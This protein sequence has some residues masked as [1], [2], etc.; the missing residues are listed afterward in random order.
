MITL[1]AQTGS[2]V[3]AL[4]KGIESVTL[5]DDL[6]AVITDGGFDAG[7]SVWHIESGEQL[8]INGDQPFPMASVFKIPV[9]AAAGLQLEQ[10]KLKLDD[11][12]PV[13]DEDKSLG[14]GIL[15]FFQAGVTPTF[16]DLLTLMII[17]SDN[18][19]TDMN[20]ALLGGPEV[21]EQAMRQ[22]GLQNIHLKMD[23]KT[24]LSYLW[25]EDIRSQPLED[26]RAWAD[27]NDIV[28]DG[29]TFSLKED[30]NIST[31][32]D[33][34]A[35]VYKLYQGEVVGGAIRDEL[36]EILLK[37]QLN[38]RLPRF[39][40]PGVKSAHKTGTIAGNA[41][42]SG[43]IYVGDDSHVIVTLFTSWDEAAV[44]NQP[45]AK[46]RRTFEVETAMGKIG[47]M[48]YDHYSG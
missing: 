12:I 30:N 41:N 38:Q 7:L 40:P 2:G 19:A 23:C 47:R 25:P 1:P 45:E 14:S 4:S 28:R 39:L 35:L 16:R 24:L 13:R 48:V 5:K 36:M 20:V 29:R 18:T 15:Q 22:L 34:S 26:I 3:R 46:Y 9:L 11:R 10:G 27:A 21:I 42:D 31:A 17:I 32:I 44:W 6:Q 33:M 8:D 43:I 37:Q